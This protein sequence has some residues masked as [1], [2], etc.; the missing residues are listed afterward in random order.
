MRVIDTRV[1][2]PFSERIKDADAPTDTD[3]QIAARAEELART[4]GNN[5]ARR[6]AGNTLVNPPTTAHASEIPGGSVVLN[7]IA[8]N[9]D[10]FSACTFDHPDHGTIVSISFPGHAL[11]LWGTPGGVHAFARHLNQLATVA[12]QHNQARLQR[13]LEQDC[14][15]REEIQRLG[16]ES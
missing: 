14:D 9:G 13:A 8:R 10:A 2:V 12:D 3:A 1:S 15:R 6:D 5:E 4:I 16:H 7:D 11:P